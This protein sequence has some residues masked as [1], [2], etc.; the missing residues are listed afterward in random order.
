[1]NL[2]RKIK[3][4]KRHRNNKHL[5]DRAELIYWLAMEDNCN[6]KRKA[7]VIS[8]LLYAIISAMYVTVPDCVKSSGLVD[9]DYLIVP[10]EIIDFCEDNPAKWLKEWCGIP[11]TDKPLYLGIDK[12]IPPKPF[13]SIKEI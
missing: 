10:R 11:S 3:N 5:R 13:V 9:N 2:K 6:N 12:P 4:C 1:M 8:E 7:F